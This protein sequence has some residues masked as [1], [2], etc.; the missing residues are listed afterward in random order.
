M[1]WDQYRSIMEQNAIK[2]D[3]MA[4]EDAYFMATHM[5]FSQLEVYDNGLTTHTPKLMTENQIFEQLIY[6]PENQHRFIIVRGSN[7]SG[8]SHLIRF[9]KA[10]LENSPSIIYNP[11]TEQLVFLRRLNNSIRGAFNQLLE[12]H[13]INNPDVEEKLKKFV[14]SST[15]KDEDSFKTE[16]L[17]AYIAAVTND[18]TNKTYKQVIC[19]NI[20]QYLSDS[21]VQDHLMRE[22]GAISRC[23]RV[24]TT[25]NS[26][27]LKETIIFTEDDFN[28]RKVNKAVLRSGNPEAQDFA[29]TIQGRG[30]DPENEIKKLVAYLNR[31]TRDV[32]QRCADISSET[33]KSVFEQLR[34][35]LKKQGK[36]LTL[37]IEDFTGFT[38]IDS[39]LITA[40]SVEHGGDY[41]YLCRVTAVIGITDGYYDQ[42]K[43]NFKERVTHQISVTERAYGSEGFLSQ[44]A[45]RYLNAIYCDPETLR[46]WYKNGALIAELPINT[47][48]V[49][50]EWES[51]NVNNEL[52]TLYP[53]NRKALYRLYESL[54]IKTPRRFLSDV[55]R[56][57][58]KEYFD[59]KK[60]QSEWL[61]PLN[62]GSIQMT[63]TPHSSAIDRLDSLS[64]EDRD[65][66]KNLLA[67][68]G[69]GSASR[70]L[71]S[72][73]TVTIGNL[74]I[75]F[76]VDIGLKQFQGIGVQKTETS[77]KPATQVSQNPLPGSS[78]KNSI[79]DAPTK[80]EDATIKNYKRWKNDI[81]SWFT[82]SDLSYHADYREWLRTFICGT[83]NVVG[84]INWQDLGIPAYIA[85]E[86]LSDKSVFYIEGQS[87]P[88]N[89]DKAIVKVNRNADGRDA[90]MALL[91]Y[92][93]GN[94]WDFN[95]AIF[96]QQKLITWLEQNK[97]NIIKNVCGSDDYNQQL[98]ITEWCL[99]LQYFRA[100]ILGNTLTGSTV[101]DKIKTLF[102]RYK[103]NKT[104]KHA[105][106]KWEDLISFVESEEASFESAYDLLTKG[107]KTMMGA[108]Q[109]AKET[110]VPAYKTDVL[111]D[112]IRHLEKSHWDIS[113]S[114]PEHPNKN[115]LYNP[116]ILLK[117]LYPRIA[118]VVEDE[119]KQISQNKDVIEYYIG[120]INRANILSTINDIQSLLSAFSQNGILGYASIRNKYDGT[121]SI[122]ADKIYAAITKVS[123]IQDLSAVEKLAILSGD[124]SEIVAD[125]R[126]DLQEIERIA[127][128]EEEKANKAMRNITGDSG[129]DT[130][131]DAAIEQ[132]KKIYNRLEGMVETNVN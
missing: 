80:K 88:G 56:S 11:A 127:S 46:N 68:W 71:K 101:I 73:T 51:E 92:Q 85:A 20:A 75:E 67:I 64:S 114:L 35:D 99:A 27:V 45:A 32:V 23:Y 103:R 55:I 53:F 90:L 121:P 82:G 79:K 89:V 49:P 76:F 37:F 29:S 22:D 57:Q 54:P 34:L 60:Y 113:N 74:P 118:V 24:I 15:A 12:Q 112:D 72:N 87:D 131:T 38:G 111:I 63:N 107:S 77:N 102:N 44:M 10:K 5:P 106:E 16:I 69:D 62:P 116:A 39:E 110:K 81:A 47:F 108:I 100:L 128:L 70:V 58:L 41:D 84:A 43:D 98:P 31:F 119:L 25:P 8:K 18:R 2:T 3:D 9:L 125:F 7:G 40:L 28:A 52:L 42:F 4:T 109:Q 36:N 83:R 1:I 104:V 117:K 61:F 30:Q 126:K 33:A 19:R 50:C 66:L 65:R 123:S 13:V 94:S 86:R 132:L 48:N 96:Y 120:H 115:L 97:A 6:N 17:Y 95:G 130:M 14:S 91:E 26:E 129:I 21:R 78:E 105:S 93:Y 124:S 59:G 122:I